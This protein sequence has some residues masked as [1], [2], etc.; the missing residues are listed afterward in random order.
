MRVQIVAGIAEG[1]RVAAFHGLDIGQFQSAE[2]MLLPAGA[3]ILLAAAHRQ[4]VVHGG[5]PAVCA[6]I[7]GE[8]L[9]QATILDGSNV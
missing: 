3:E 1:E 5:Q 2:G 8:S 6:V 7:A 4:F 9:F